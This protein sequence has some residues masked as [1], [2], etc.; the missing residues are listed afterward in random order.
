M[1]QQAKSGAP[2]SGTGSRKRRR[3]SANLTT[4]TARQGRHKWLKTHLWHAKRFHMIERWGYR[5]P[6]RPCDKAFRACYRAS[7]QHCLVQD[8]S[9]YECVQLL[10]DESVIVEGMKSLGDATTGLSVAAKAYIKGCCRKH[11]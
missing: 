6:D 2:R 1:S 11:I 3:R 4:L 7:A 8:I 5:L 10:G 9:Y